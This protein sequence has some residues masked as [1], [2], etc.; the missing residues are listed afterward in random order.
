MRSPTNIPQANFVL[1]W[2]WRRMPSLSFCLCG[3]HQKTCR[4]TDALLM[5]LRCRFKM[6]DFM[7]WCIRVVALHPTGSWWGFRHWYEAASLARDQHLSQ[8]RGTDHNALTRPTNST[9][10]ANWSSTLRRRIG[11]YSRS[12]HG[13]VRLLCKP[14]PPRQTRITAK[15]QQPSHYASRVY[16]DPHSP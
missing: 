9:L 16:S 6:Q 1:L 15:P 8:N 10:E 7:V 5:I 4:I 14:L 11:C 3:V 13:F 12:T 2:L